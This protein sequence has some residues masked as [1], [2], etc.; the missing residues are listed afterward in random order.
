MPILLI[1]STGSIGAM[2]ALFL[3]ESYAETLKYAKNIWKFTSNSNHYT[4]VF[5]ERKDVNPVILRFFRE[6][7]K[8]RVAVFLNFMRIIK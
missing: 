1:H 7:I 8:K 3:A 4:L 5:E 2:P 6:F